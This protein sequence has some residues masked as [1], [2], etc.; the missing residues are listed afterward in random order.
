MNKIITII[1][2]LIAVFTISS[3]EKDFSQGGHNTFYDVFRV[4]NNTDYGITLN[5]FKS[6][7]RLI[8]GLSIGPQKSFN[9][10]DFN[11]GFADS[12]DVIFDDN[13]Y[14]RLYDIGYLYQ[15]TDITPSFGNCF[16]KYFSNDKDAECRVFSID[17]KMKS[18]AKSR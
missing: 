7:N 15:E 17:Y 12:L 2:G 18:F 16:N 6:D 9:L 13:K 11:L 3:C 10:G 8:S 1:F 14:I 5:V 4:D